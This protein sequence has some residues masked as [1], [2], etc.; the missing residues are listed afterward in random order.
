VLIGLVNVALWINR[1]YFGGRFDSI[2][3]CSAH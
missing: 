2:E 3:T 1:R